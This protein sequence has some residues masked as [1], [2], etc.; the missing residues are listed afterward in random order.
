M[1]NKGPVETAM[2]IQAKYGNFEHGFIPH[3]PK[4]KTMGW[5]FSVC[6]LPSP[7][8]AE[9]CYKDGSP[10]P[11]QKELREMLAEKFLNVW[12]SGYGEESSLKCADI[13]LQTIKE[14]EAQRD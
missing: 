7:S 12:N 9:F 4:E 10:R 8:Y 6:G 14:F 3:E 11:K 2:E 5:N 13:A 1:R